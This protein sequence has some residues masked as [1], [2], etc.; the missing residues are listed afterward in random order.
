L[1]KRNEALKKL[2]EL[3]RELI[4]K[5]KYATAIDSPCPEVEYGAKHKANLA[6]SMRDLYSGS[7]RLQKRM[8]MTLDTQDLKAKEAQRRYYHY[9]YLPCVPTLSKGH[10]RELQSTNSRRSFRKHRQKT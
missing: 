1:A 7:I 2:T 8:T 5:G 10:N 3:Q 9:H 4:E 6:A